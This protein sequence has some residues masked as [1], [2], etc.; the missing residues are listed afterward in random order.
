M[1]LPIKDM[2][3]RTGLTQ[4]DTARTL[5]LEAITPLKQDGI[6]LPLDEALDRIVAQDITAQENLPPQPRSVMD[7]FAVRAADTFGASPSMPT[8]LEISGQVDMGEIPQG[9]VEQGK[10]YRIATGGFLPQGADAVVILEDTVPINE[11][12]IEVVQGVGPGS[13]I[14]KTGEDIAQGETAISRGHKLRP[15]DLGLLAGLGI[16]EVTVTP[17]VRVGI[18]S[19]GDEIIAPSMAMVPGKIR[20]CNA[21]TLAALVRRIGGEPHN[22]GIVKDVR[23]IFFPALEKAA[24]ENDVVLF[25]GGSSVGV[26]D[27]GEQAVAALGPPGIFLHGVA[28]KPGKPLLVGFSDKTL[29]VGLPGHPVSAMTCFH[30]FIAPA[31]KKLSGETLRPEMPTATVTAQLSRNVNSA[32]GRR[33]VIRVRLIRNADDTLLAEPIM[34][35]SGAISTLSRADGYVIIEEDKQG[36]AQGSITE[37][38]RYL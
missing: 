18:V 35:K 4:V 25:S 16:T 10:C 19:T 13:H 21:T 27:L 24:A 32:A 26:R 23:E 20:D 3:G 28:L 2:L 8:Y 9:Q 6:R 17:R 12:T 37:A 31:I 38:F 15:Q 5:L 34:G 36:L 22:Y 29:L 14:I 1:T 30:L 11:T 33:D 7:G